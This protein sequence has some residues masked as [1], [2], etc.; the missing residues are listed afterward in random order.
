MEPPNIKQEV[1]PEGSKG[2][3]REIDRNNDSFAQFGA[4]VAN[5]L[6]E[7]QLPKGALLALQ[8]EILA[9]IARHVS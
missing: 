6:R 3:A 9:T 5:H 2:T 1:E 7:S 4:S 8:G